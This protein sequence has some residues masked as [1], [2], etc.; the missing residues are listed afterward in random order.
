MVLRA[1]A[2][3]VGGAGFRWSH[4]DRVFTNGTSVLP[5][6]AYEKPF[7]LYHVRS[8]EKTSSISQRRGSHQTL[9]DSI[10]V[11]YFLAFGTRRKIVPLIIS[12]PVYGIWL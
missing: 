11:L 3:G 4:E 9:T 8:Q 1:K 2:I 6:D 12:H 10:L 5:K 7:T